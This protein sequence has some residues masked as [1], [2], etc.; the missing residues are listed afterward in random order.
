LRSRTTRRFREAFR[1]LPREIQE[2]TRQAYA[3]FRE[4]PSHP[5]LRL[6]RIQIR[7]NVH[8]ARIT[9]D[10]RAVGTVEGD[11]V[12]W[13]WVGSHKDYERLIKQL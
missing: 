1:E 4:N 12:V 6:K 10:Y 11:E 8:S 5:G 2:Q 9:R 13:F 3:R 7:G